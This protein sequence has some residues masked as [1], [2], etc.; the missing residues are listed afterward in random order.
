MIDDPTAVTT[1]RRDWLGDERAERGAWREL[2]RLVRR[3][4]RRWL[5][6]VGYALVCS[7]LAAGAALRSP[8]SYASRVVFRVA[9]TADA[10]L[11]DY[12]GKVVLSRTRLAA[13]GAAR[14]DLDVELRAGRLAL[15]YRAGDAQRA[16]DVVAQLGALVVD[17]ERGRELVL[18]DPGHVE[19]PGMGRGELAL[20]LAACVFVAALPLCAIGVG[21][22]DPRVYDLD[23]VRRLGLPTVGAVRPFEG[24]NAG[25]LAARLRAEGRARITRS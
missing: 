16:Y 9:G 2:G 5:R 25:A 21:A 23:D 3:A 8:P 17:S 22:F 6:V 11:R 1:V 20:W 14:D 19:L 18:I 13:A 12:V 15:T 10:A 7:A 4:R 24:D